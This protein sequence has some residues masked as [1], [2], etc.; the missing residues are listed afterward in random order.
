M[1][2]SGVVTGM[3]TMTPQAPELFTP[4]QAISEVG[5]CDITKI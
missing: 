5:S 3:T 2:N 4:A 1:C